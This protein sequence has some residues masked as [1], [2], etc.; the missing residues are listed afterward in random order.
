MIMKYYLI[1]T[2]QGETFDPNGDVSDNL[3]VLDLVRARSSKHA[4]KLYER[5]ECRQESFTHYWTLE[6]NAQHLHQ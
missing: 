1:V 2:D 6:V 5:E 4:I 3:Q